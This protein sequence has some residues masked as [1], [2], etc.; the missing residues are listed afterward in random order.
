MRGKYATLA[1]G[2]KQT[3]GTLRADDRFRIVLFNTSARE[4]ASGYVTASPDAVK[5]W[6]DEVARIQPGAGAAVGLLLVA[7]L[8]EPLLK[9]RLWMLLTAGAL[10]IDLAVI[11]L[12]PNVVH[13][14]GLSGLDNLMVGAGLVASY[15]KRDPLLGGFALFVAAKI[16]VEN[17]SHH[18]LF[19]DTAWT[20]LNEAHLAG[21]VAGV[22]LA[23][24]A[25]SRIDWRGR[26]RDQKV[27]NNLSP[28]S[29]SRRNRLGR[30]PLPG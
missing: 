25:D 24:F 19:T 4:L 27:S 30:F 21:Y 12:I 1:E 13:Y 29:F 22:V 11:M 15:R 5:H 10:A 17:I 28:A 16:A 9:D 14:G 3:L 26:R 18:A 7:L 20:S 23:S 6:A 2:V 8:Y